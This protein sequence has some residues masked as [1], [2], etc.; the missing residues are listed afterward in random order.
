MIATFKEN[1]DVEL[2]EE[3]E[4]NSGTFTFMKGKSYDAEYKGKYLYISNVNGSVIIALN[5]DY[6]KKYI[7]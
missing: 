7:L 2:W 6:Q 3:D 1:Y 4:I 5:K